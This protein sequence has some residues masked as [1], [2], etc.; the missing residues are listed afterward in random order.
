MCCLAGSILHNALPETSPCKFCVPS[1]RPSAAQSAI[2]TV[3][4]VLKEHSL[5]NQMI[6]L[7]SLLLPYLPVPLLRP[8]VTAII[9]IATSDRSSSSPEQSPLTSTVVL[10]LDRRLAVDHQVKVFG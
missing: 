1:V 10:V 6:L 5:A 4:E 7:G 2:T 9:A 8:R 3:C